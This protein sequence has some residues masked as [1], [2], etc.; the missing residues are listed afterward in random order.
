MDW[1]VKQRILWT[2]RIPVSPIQRQSSGVDSEQG[3]QCAKL[4]SW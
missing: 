3:L 2:R 1:E 4:P